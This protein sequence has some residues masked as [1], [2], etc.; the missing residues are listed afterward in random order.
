MTDLRELADDVEMG[1]LSAEAALRR[2][3]RETAERDA[4]QRE[5]AAG[6]SSGRPALSPAV[7]G[8]RGEVPQDL[9]GRRSDGHPSAPSRQRNRR[10]LRAAAPA[11][12]YQAPRVS[13]SSLTTLS[14]RI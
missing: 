5:P 10:C 9:A 2:V 1:L 3:Q 7:R 11:A 14:R 4:V 8:D 12:C 6:Q 13:W